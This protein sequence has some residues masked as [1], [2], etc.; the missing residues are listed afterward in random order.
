MRCWRQSRRP[1][2]W[3]VSCSLSLTVLAAV[4]PCINRPA[5]YSLGHGRPAP[6]QYRKHLC[7]IAD[8]G[9]L[10][11]LDKSFAVNHRVWEQYQ[12]AS[13]EPPLP[14]DLAE[15]AGQAVRTIPVRIGDDIAG[16]PRAEKLRDIGL[17]IRTSGAVRED[18][19]A[20]LFNDAPSKVAT[21]S[22]DN[23]NQYELPLDVR[24]VKQ[25][26]NQ[27][28]LEIVHRDASARKEVVVEAVNVDVRYRQ[29]QAGSAT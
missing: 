26:V 27:P 7:E 14:V 4:Y 2:P 29:K 16:A 12:R 10:K 1:L 28:K 17:W 21:N 22:A 18:A 19:L 8:P 15:Q 5:I 13:A 25:G 11:Y 24:T 23:D 9:K 6:E 20:V 3:V